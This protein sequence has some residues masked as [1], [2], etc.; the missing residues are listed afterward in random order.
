MT[1]SVVVVVIGLSLPL[2]ARILVVDDDYD[3]AFAISVM[4]KEHGFS[5]EWYTDPLVAL[6]TFR[7]GRYDLVLLDAR[8]PGLDGFA[9]FE[10]I[11]KIDPSV[12]PC[13]LTASY[14]RGYED[15]HNR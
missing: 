11:H 5:T 15:M 4:L 8:M 12:R 6:S 14:E 9:L 10:S 3:S 13:F 7:Q 1:Q 2:K